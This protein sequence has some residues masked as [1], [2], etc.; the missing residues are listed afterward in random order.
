[1]FFFLFRR[2]HPAIRLAVGIAVLIAGVVIH[3]P[4]LD[5]VGA[6]MVLVGAITWKSRK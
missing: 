6:A 5:V 2:V 1:M 4:I 3:K